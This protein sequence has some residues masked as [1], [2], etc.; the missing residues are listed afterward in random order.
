M[1][2]EPMDANG[3]VK[4]ILLDFGHAL[5]ANMVDIRYLLEKFSRDPIKCVRGGLAG[6]EPI[7]NG[8]WSPEAEQMFVSLISGNT[9][10][11]T[12]VSYDVEESSYLLELSE[13]LTA[14]FSINKQLVNAKMAR[15]VNSD[16][17]PYAILL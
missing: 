3:K 6:V 13:R 9:L 10:H 17:Y 7:S 16:K 5:E 11:G 2:C 8:K 14:E 15:Q 4:V 12:L 1:I